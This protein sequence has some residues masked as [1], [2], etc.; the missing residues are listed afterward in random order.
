MRAL[1]DAGKGG[2]MTRWKATIT[3]RVEPTE[4]GKSINVDGEFLEVEHDIEEIGEL[5]RIVE[6]GPHWDTIEKIEIV[7][8]RPSEDATLTV[9]EAARR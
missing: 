5:E 7:L 2:G 1:H 6:L 9:E 4:F 8:Q 3:Y